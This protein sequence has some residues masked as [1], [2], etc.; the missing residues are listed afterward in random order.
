VFLYEIDNYNNE[1]SVIPE[2]RQYFT[3]SDLGL[4]VNDVHL[5]IGPGP[6]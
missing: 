5:W 6:L 4:K 1:E 3:R 2:K